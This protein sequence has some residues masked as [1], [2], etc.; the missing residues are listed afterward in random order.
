MHCLHLHLVVH[1]RVISLP[2]ALLAMTCM[3]VLDVASDVLRECCVRG[4]RRYTPG[5]SSL[6]PWAAM[7]STIIR[8]AAEAGRI[9]G[10]VKVGRPLHVLTR[11]DWF[12]GYEPSYVRAQQ[13]MAA[14][15]CTL[16][17]LAGVVA[18]ACRFCVKMD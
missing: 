1:N 17:L 16:C 6:R 5:P 15:K 12:C 8:S 10:H 7:A 13:R 9:Y 3:V 4:R 14:F 11:F 2:V 18:W